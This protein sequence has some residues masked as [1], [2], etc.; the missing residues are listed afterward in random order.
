MNPLVVTLD[1]ASFFLND[2]I[3]KVELAFESFYRMVH[4]ANS[5]FGLIVEG[6][7]EFLVG[8]C[9]QEKETILDVSFPE[10]G[11]QV[12]HADKILGFLLFWLLSQFSRLNR[13]RLFQSKVDEEI[14]ILGAALEHDQGPHLA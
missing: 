2:Y 12:V 5:E 1:V 8:E 7:R 14:V 4:V 3:L 11:G 13:D 6:D 10:P 9:G